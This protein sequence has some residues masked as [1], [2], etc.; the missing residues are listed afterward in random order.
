[1]GIALVATVFLLLLKTVGGIWAGSIALLS[2]A[3]HSL[4]DVLSL[5][6][7]FWAIRVAHRPP[8]P[9]RTYGHHR[10]GILVAMGNS[11]MLILLSF[12]FLFESAKLLLHPEAVKAPPMFLISLLGLLVNG[13]LTLLLANEHHD[14][15]IRSA[16][17]HLAGDA[18]TSF[19]VMIAA[20]LIFFTKQNFWDPIVSILI[21]LVIIFQAYRIIEEAWN[22]LMEGTPTGLDLDA[23][24]RSMQEISGVM[25]VHHVHIWSISP[26]RVAL[27]GHLVVCDGPLRDGERIVTQVDR[28][29]SSRFQIIHSTL[30]IET[31]LQEECQ[32]G[33]CHPQ[34]PPP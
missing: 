3:G 22:V 29:L 17:L 21:A 2:D 26:G 15:N 27:S 24:V 1:M 34:P 25:G 33:D 6:L 7:S 5:G 8:T 10:F 19:G 23:V 13:L 18:A 30:Q 31:H 20:A 28:L 4:T 11:V 12:A 9:M 32:T 16:W 14:L